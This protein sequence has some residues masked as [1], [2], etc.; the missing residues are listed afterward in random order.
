MVMNSPDFLIS[1]E[2]SSK[3]EATQYASELRDKLLATSP[4][5]SVDYER[6]AEDTQDFGA[7]LAVV[8]GTPAVLAVAQGIKAWL[9]SR[10]TAGITISGSAGEVIIAGLTSADAAKID[11][12]QIASALRLHD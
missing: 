6:D 10:P 12:A 9:A 11:A 1:F 4:D 8:L 7:T 5:V 2:N 3:A